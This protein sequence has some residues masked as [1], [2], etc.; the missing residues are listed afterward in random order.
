MEKSIT[1]VIETERTAY[2]V[3]EKAASFFVNDREFA[4]FLKC[5]SRDERLH[6]ELLSE[7]A[8][9]IKEQKNFILPIQID[10]ETMQTVDNYFRL[11]EDRID[12]ETLSKENMI[13][14]I[15][16]TEFSE[17]NDIFLYVLNS[18]KGSSNNS[19][20][21]AAKIQQHKKYIERFF[22][23][24]HSTRGHFEAIKRLPDTWNENILTVENDSMMAGLF[25][26]I[27]G[28]EGIVDMAVNGAEGL[29][30]VIEKDYSIIVAEADLPDMNGIDF[31]KKVVERYQRLH[32]RFLFITGP[33]YEQYETFF[34]ENNIK[35]FIKPT[36]I[37]DIKKEVI[38]IL[39]R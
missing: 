28:E 24:W 16:S 15:I 30:K 9:A 2:R 33:G 18:I 37:S 39:N 5:L 10:N 20:Q 22:K 35:Y 19:V 17:Y 8:E 21:I 25:E 26:V 34:K 1:W 36:L 4:N 27:L 7:A 12:S 31:Y 6:Y 14:C 38:N 32:D 29:K 23:K 11:V 3:Y 13:Q